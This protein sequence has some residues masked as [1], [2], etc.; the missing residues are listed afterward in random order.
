MKSDKIQE[1]RLRDE[2]TKLISTDRKTVLCPH[3]SHL[4]GLWYRVGTKGQKS[5]CFSCDNAKHIWYETIRDRQGNPVVVEGKIQQREC[6]RTATRTYEA[7][8]FIP[9]LP[10]QELWTPGRK[11]EAQKKQQYQLAIPIKK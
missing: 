3:C 11:A 8:V 4:H 2:F 7:P 10:I 5:L 9:D 6:F 1:Q